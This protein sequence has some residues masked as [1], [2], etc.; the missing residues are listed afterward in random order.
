LSFGDCFG[1]SCFHIVLGA[2]LDLI[3]KISFF[4]LRHS[5]DP[6]QGRY[7]LMYNQSVLGNPSWR[8][9]ERSPDNRE[10]KNRHVEMCFSQKVLGEF[11]IQKY[12]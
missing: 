12:A 9:G 3:Q 5:E 7:A 2:F 1:K 6:A 4:I 11:L 8:R 10:F